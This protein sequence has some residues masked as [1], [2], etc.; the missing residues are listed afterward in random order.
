M[1]YYKITSPGRVSH[2]HPFM[3]LGSDSLA[4][5]YM[6]PDYYDRDTEP[7]NYTH[8]L[9]FG[10]DASGI[11]DTVKGS[12]LKS[13]MS[14]VIAWGLASAVGATP[15]VAR[16]IGIVSGGVDLIVGVAMTV[17]RGDVQAQVTPAT[18]TEQQEP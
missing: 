12:A 9:G 13:L 7:G 18:V 3:G 17:L 8:L 10:L 4:K 14:G 6:R 16:R 5:A 1:P 15:T 2:R 11:Y